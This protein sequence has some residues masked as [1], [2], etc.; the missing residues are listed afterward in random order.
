MCVCVCA[1]VCLWC[2]VCGGVE[3]AGVWAA[4]CAAVWAAA[5]R[6]LPVLLSKRPPGLLSGLLSGLPSELLPG[7]LSG[8]MPVVLLWLLHVRKRVFKDAPEELAQWA[9][10]VFGGKRTDEEC[11]E[12]LCMLVCDH[13]PT[14]SQPTSDQHLTNTCPIF[15]HVLTTLVALFNETKLVCVCV[16]VVVVVVWG[17]GERV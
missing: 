6:L 17:G 15:G 16:C 3:M 14:G 11:M 4:D 7:L 5:F 9:S 2:G 8:L 12:E 10:L 1:R 13:L